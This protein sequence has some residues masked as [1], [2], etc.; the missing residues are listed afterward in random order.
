MVFLHRTP[1]GQRRYGARQCG[2]QCYIFNLF[3][4]VFCTKTY[5]RHVCERPQNTTKHNKAQ[6]TRDHGG[7][8]LA[9]PAA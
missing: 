8:P 1:A 4:K 3:L 9:T 2:S 7:E 5:I 6:K